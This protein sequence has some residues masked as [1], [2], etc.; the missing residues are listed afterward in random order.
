M[1]Y[2]LDFHCQ[3]ILDEYREN[4]AIFEKMREIVR[5]QLE[6]CVADNNIYVTG[7]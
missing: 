1:E 6:K 7:I 2:N 5:A 3:M 4:I